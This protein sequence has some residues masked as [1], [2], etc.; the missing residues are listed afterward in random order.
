[1]TKRYVELINMGGDHCGM[2][3]L[4]T[5][6]DP[7]FECDGGCSRATQDV[8]IDAKDHDAE[9]AR[10]KAEIEECRARANERADLMK[11]A[12][13]VTFEHAKL[14]L[15]HLKEGFSVYDKASVA[16]K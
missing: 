8:W 7:Q 3:D 16:L 5:Y 13:W 6:A 15:P 9:I 10:L 2:G 14:H 1:M 12:L 4:E 11:D